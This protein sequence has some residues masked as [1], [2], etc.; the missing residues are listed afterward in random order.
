MENKA[1]EIRNMHFSYPKLS[2]IFDGLSVCFKPSKFSVLLGLNGSG[3]S[4][5]FRIIAGLQ[6]DFGGEVYFF[7]TS[8]KRF[9]AKEKAATIGFLS[10]SFEPVFPFSVKEILETGRSAFSTFSLTSKDEDRIEK[11]AKQLGIHSLLNVNFNALSG[12]QQQRV[13]IGRILVQNPKI[14]LLD[15]PTNHLDIH[16]QHEL[17][18]YLHTLTGEGYTILAIMHDPAL[19]LRYADEVFVLHE[20]NIQPMPMHTEAQ[21]ELL[22]KVFSLDFTTI[23]L[24]NERV[25]IPRKK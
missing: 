19:A 8:A 15:E 24:E 25:V 2:P 16:Q 13:L 12:G 9:S 7:G 3:K 5:L 18:A 23:Q 11:V 22:K 1:I 4:T 21:E 14:I 17:M 6:K 10:Q 20:K